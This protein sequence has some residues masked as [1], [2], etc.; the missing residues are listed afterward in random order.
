MMNIA[1]VTFLYGA[2]IPVLFMIAT[3]S[4]SLFYILERILIAYSFKQPPS[5]DHRINK[6]T[7]KYLMFAPLIFLANGYWMYSN[8]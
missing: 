2:G 3:V 4:Y 5:F 1:F 7:V 6:T 8:V